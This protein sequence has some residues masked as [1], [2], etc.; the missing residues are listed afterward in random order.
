MSGYMKQY[1]FEQDKFQVNLRDNFK[2]IREQEEIK[3][4]K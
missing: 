2:G 1:N 3:I 4:Q